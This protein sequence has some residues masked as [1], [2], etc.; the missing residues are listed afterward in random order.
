M[1]VMAQIESTIKAGGP[2]DA[3]TNILNQFEQ[4]IQD[5]QVAHQ[6]LYD[7]Q[8]EECDSEIKFRQGEIREANDAIHEAANTLDSCESQHQRAKTDLKNSENQLANARQSLGELTRRKIEYDYAHTTFVTA[9]NMALDAFPHCYKLLDELENGSA[10]FV[11]ITSHVTKMVPNVAK[12]T[13]LKH[14]NGLLATLAQV[15]GLG[16]ADRV[17]VA[18]IRDTL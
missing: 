2:M 13:N 4:E 9:S 14:M 1:N 8:T 17:A 18:K 5:E 3:I 7:R 15:A 12:V 11:Q 10:S 6:E 16:N